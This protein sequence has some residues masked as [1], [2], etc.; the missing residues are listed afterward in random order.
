MVQSLETPTATS[1]PA[2]VGTFQ[3]VTLAL[4]AATC[5]GAALEL[6]M[7]RHWGTRTQ[8]LAWLVLGIVVVGVVLRAISRSITAV[9]TARWVAVLAVIGSGVG[10]YFHLSSNLEIGPNNPAYRDTWDSMSVISQWWA[11]ATG[12]VGATPLLAPGMIALAG[13]LL[14]VS[15]IGM[16]A[17]TG[18][19]G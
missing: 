7:L 14:A 8:L 17:R 5:L 12:S 18:R 11:A 9:R 13:I 1:D 16:S 2:V 15:T 19:A 4:A 10:M 3:R 6:A